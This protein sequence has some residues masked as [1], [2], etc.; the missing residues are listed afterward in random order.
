MLRVDPNNPRAAEVRDR[1]AARIDLSALPEELCLVVGGD[2][3]MLQCIREL[4]T[5]PIY[6]GLNAGRVGFLLNDTNGGTEVLDRVAR[7]LAEGRWSAV[8]FPLLRFSATSTDGA[9]IAG[10][11][12]NDVYVERMSGQ[13]AHLRVDLEG[14]TVLDR[15]VCD[16]LIVATALGSTAYSFSA[17]GV[18]SHPLVQAMQVT[19]ICPHVPRISPVVLPPTTT[20]AVEALDPARR[21]VRVVSDGVEQGPIRRMAVDWAHQEV[22]LAFLEGHHITRTL[23]R[24]VLK[25]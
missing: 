15:L 2:G 1:L 4:G 21:P 13:I 24:K 3:W 7:A 5:A 23:I 9:E 10:V 12:V 22:R 8:G 20:V 6:L 16:G 14:V 17:G 25:G 18:P 19:P 11:A